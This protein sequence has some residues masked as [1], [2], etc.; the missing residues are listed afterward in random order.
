MVLEGID[1]SGKTS[2]GKEVVSRLNALGVPAGF[3][4]EPSDLP[5][6]RL[7]REVLRGEFSTGPHTH[8][9][10]FAADREEHLR[11]VVLPG[12][13][14]GLIMVCDRYVYA[15]MAYQGARGVDPEEIWRMNAALPHFR[16]PDLAFLLD[17]PPGVGLGRTS[18]RGEA[19]IFETPEYLSRVRERYLSMAETRGLRIIDATL[20]MEEVAEAVV[21][22]ILD[23]RGS[24]YGGQY[25][26]H[27]RTDP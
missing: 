19:D 8:A 15:S 12:I 1:G 17:L 14:S 25:G 10:L 26:V 20:P 18:H 5:V 4:F 24:G 23:L 2:V 9:L 11:E 22:A 27:L 6:G 21:R 3:T 13:R 16:R 7:L